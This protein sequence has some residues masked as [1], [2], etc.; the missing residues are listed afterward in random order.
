MKIELKDLEKLV[1]TDSTDNWKFIEDTITSADS[2][3]GGA[4]HDLIIQNKLDNK[5]YIIEYSDWDI[6]NEDLINYTYSDLE[7]VFP[8]EI[9]KTI[10]VSKSKL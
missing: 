6:E 1:Y 4:Y 7:E 3:D 5:F 10:Y 2:E 9:Q 8:K